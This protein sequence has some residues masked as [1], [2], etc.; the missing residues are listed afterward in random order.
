M[1]AWNTKLLTGFMREKA[2]HF[3]NEFYAEPQYRK[4]KIEVHRGLG[5]LLCWPLFPQ[6]T[7]HSWKA[8]CYCLGNLLFLHNPKNS[9]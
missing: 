8:Q 3:S 6:P 1:R 2:S 5:S 7:H 9:F 4:A